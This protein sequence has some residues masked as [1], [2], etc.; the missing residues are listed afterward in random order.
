M[1][2]VGQAAQTQRMGRIFAAAVGGNPSPGAGDAGSADIPP[3]SVPISA[4]AGAAVHPVAGGIVTAL[5]GVPDNASVRILH[6][7]GSSATYGGLGLAAV[8]P[9]ELVTPAH[10]IGSARPVVTLAATM[11]SGD[12]GDAGA[13]LRSAGGPAT[14]IGADNTL[15]AWDPQ[16]VVDR[17][18]QRQ[19]I[20]PDE[21]SIALGLA[22][23]R[24]A[25]DQAQQA[26]Q[27]LAA[28]RTVVSLAGAAPG[29]VA[30]AADLP[31]ELTAQMSPA[32][33][34]GVDSTLRGVAQAAFDPVPD[35]PAALRL[36]ILQRQDPGQFAQTNLAPF[37]GTIHPADLLKL[38]ADQARITAG[39]NPDLAQGS[40]TS[41]LDAMARH[42][43]KAGVSLPDQALPAIKNR[44]E[45][46]L[47][48]NQTEM[49]DHQS[50][51]NA[52]TDA[53]Q[54]QVDP[55]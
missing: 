27:D 16:A 51:A 26:L 32:M 14:V 41:V 43:F 2:R 55:G 13:L 33:L 38:A 39:Q 12:V 48:L 19:D 35:H 24:M 44:A 8:A 31:P 7:D 1:A 4:R 9:G 54:N 49:S 10:V 3:G 40:R 52:V 17:I 42:E 5:G 22:Q 23:R 47:R 34:A 50:I 11:P 30:Q 18:A 20:S 25:A 37:M 21:R 53:I 15:R 46:Q 28:G 45:A 36:E 29:T 6:P